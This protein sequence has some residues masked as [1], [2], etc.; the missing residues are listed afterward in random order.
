[1]AIKWLVGGS[2]SQ[3]AHAILD[4]Y[5][6]ETITILAPDFIR[7]EVANILWN[8]QRLAGLKRDT[9]REALEE[10][11][12]TEIVYTSADELLVDAFQLALHHERT[13]YD[14]LYLALSVRE[15][16]QLVTADEK[17]YNAVS[18]AMSNVV[19]LTNWP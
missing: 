10:F 12:A 5:R 19:L 17:L 11:L 6:A 1:V 16:C 7:I 4:G 9:A 2:Y 15:Q 14:S 8:L 18:N 3:H 13:V